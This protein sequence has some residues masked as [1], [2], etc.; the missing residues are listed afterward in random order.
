MGRLADIIWVAIEN[1]T[2]ECY[3]NILLQKD[4]FHIGI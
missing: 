4:D 1:S 2:V 3:V